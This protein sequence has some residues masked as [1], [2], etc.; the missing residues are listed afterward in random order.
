MS[1]PI[2]SQTPEKKPAD[3]ENRRRLKRRRRVKFFRRPTG[4]PP[5]SIHGWQRPLF[6]LAILLFVGLW[7]AAFIYVL[8]SVARPAPG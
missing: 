3:S 5:K 4:I 1:G 7:F 6:V 2:D 8:N